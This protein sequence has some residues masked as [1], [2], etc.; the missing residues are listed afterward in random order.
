MLTI[1]LKYNI[2]KYIITEVIMIER[3]FIRLSQKISRM[4][5]VVN[6]TDLTV[7]DEKIEPRPNFTVIGTWETEVTEM[8]HPLEMDYTVIEEQ[9]LIV[10]RVDRDQ[11]TIAVKE[12]PILTI[13]SKEDEIVIPPKKKDDDDGREK[14][15]A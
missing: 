2:V 14:V 9:E 4:Q 11:F 3:G 13:T 12:G 6:S 8:T 5:V 15:L 7:I 1:T 10:I